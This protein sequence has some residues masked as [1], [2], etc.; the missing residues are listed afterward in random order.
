MKVFP[1]NHRAT[2]WRRS[3]WLGILLAS[4]LASRAQWGDDAFGGYF[5]LPVSEEANWTRHFR[6]G[7]LMGLNLKASFAMDGTFSVSGNNP[8]QAGTAGQGQ[9]HFYDDGYVRVDDTGNAGGWTTYWGY[10]NASQYDAGA[11]T[12]TFHGASQFTGASSSSAEGESQLGLDLAYGGK[13]FELEAGEVGWEFGFGWLPMSLRSQESF[14]AQVTRTVHQ[15][16]TGGTDV[17]GAPYNG[18]FSSDGYPAIQDLPTA[19]IEAPMNLSVSATRELDVTLYSFRLGPTF[20]WEPHRR[21]AFSVSGG[22]VMGLV[23]GEFKFRESLLVSGTTAVNAGSISSTELTYGGYVSATLMFHAVENG[24]FYLGMQYMP[25]GDATFSGVGRQA[26]LDM[27][28]A[29]Y[30]SAGINWPF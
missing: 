24:D 28:G 13:L 15:Y 12:L 18:G 25:L 21:I 14:N 29:V 26:N 27:S 17:P 6:L 16:N 8:G 7:A 3:S 2:L 23:S 10:N 30:I 4:S 20:Q 19:L 11:Q 9:D 1:T 22:A 5:G